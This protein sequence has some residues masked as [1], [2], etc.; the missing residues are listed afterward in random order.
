V[1]HARTVPRLIFYSTLILRPPDRPRRKNGG[2]MGM[3]LFLRVN[4]VEVIRKIDL[5][6]WECGSAK[7]KA[8]V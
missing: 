2:P 4:S 6:W 1:A 3:S 7:V 5:S 8:T